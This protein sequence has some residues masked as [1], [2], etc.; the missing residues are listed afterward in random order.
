MTKMIYGKALYLEFADKSNGA[1]QILVTPDII[2]PDGG[3]IQQVV[4]RR[5]VTASKPRT[6]WKAYSSYSK[7]PMEAGEFKQ[8]NV[9]EANTTAEAMLYYALPLFK[10]VLDYKYSLRVKP[11]VVE[12]NGDDL[13]DLNA[14]KTPY[15]ILSRV[16]KSRKV[17]GFPDDLVAATSL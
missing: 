11:V 14:H 8:L 13:F 10:Q 4:Y 2:G 9:T 5:R 16:N 1:L 12:I 17:L 7:V 15:K 6:T 3:Y